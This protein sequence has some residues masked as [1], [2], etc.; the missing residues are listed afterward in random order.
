MTNNKDSNNDSLNTSVQQFVLNK[1][2]ENESDSDD[3]QLNL[4]FPEKNYP[5]VGNQTIVKTLE[6]SSS[7][8]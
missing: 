3:E 2:L 5:V 6:E 7:K 4:I 8:V 1:S